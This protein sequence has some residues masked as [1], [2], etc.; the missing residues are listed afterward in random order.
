MRWDAI[1]LLDEADV[2]LE[3]RTTQDM[4]RNSVLSGRFFSIFTTY[5]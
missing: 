2:Y 3:Q 1:L 4:E 5:L